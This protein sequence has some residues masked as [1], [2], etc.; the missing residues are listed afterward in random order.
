MAL[1][2]GK[3]E[4]VYIQGKVSWFKPSMTNKW[5]KY[6]TQI[7]PNPE[8]LEKIRDLQA[9]GMKNQIKK[10]EDGYYCTFTRP[11]SKEFKSGKIITY[12]PVEVFDKD[13][14]PF[15]E[16]VGNGTDA[17]LKIEVYEHP[18]PSGGKA[19]ASRWVSAR[20]DNLIPYVPNRDNTDEQKVSAEGLEKQPEQLF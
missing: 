6:S 8:G 2:Y 4:Y 19:K 9:E 7:H 1:K 5:N 14:K 17:T 12:T 16:L 15:T 20:I 3:T 11:V 13:G 10:D 18:T